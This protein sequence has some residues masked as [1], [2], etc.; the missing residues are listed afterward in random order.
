MSRLQKGQYT[1]RIYEESVANK[2]DDTFNKM[3]SLFTSKNSFISRCVELG[4]EELRKQYSLKNSNSTMNHLEK[5][6]AIS[7]ELKIMAQALKEKTVRDSVATEIDQRNASCLYHMILNLS[8]GTPLSE[9]EIEGGLY[10]FMPERY[11]N[12]MLELMEQFK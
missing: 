3:A 4:V 12:E 8:K 5:L 7:K 1:V 2:I 9:Q 10:D 11:K 6:D